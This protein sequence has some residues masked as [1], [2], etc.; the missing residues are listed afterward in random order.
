MIQII[1]CTLYGGQKMLINDF[2]AFNKLA[3]FSGR[4]A[5]VDSPERCLAGLK[6]FESY[7]Y[8]DYDYKFNSWG[9]RGPEYDQY[10]GK[11]VNIC[12]GDSYTTNLGGP[13]EHSWPSILQE[14]Y[15]IPC[16]NLGL[17]GAGNDAIRLIYERA[18]K[19]FDVKKTFIQYSLIHRRLENGVLMHKHAYMYTNIHP[20][21]TKD[22]IIHFQQNFVKGAYYNFLPPWF[23][24]DDEL[25]FINSIPGFAGFCV[26]RWHYWTKD[27]PRILCE[28]N[29]YN[30]LKGPDWPSFEDFLEGAEPH[31][32]MFEE[33]YKVRTRKY[34][35]R[36]GLHFSLEGNQLLAEN[37]YNQ[38]K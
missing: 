4:Y 14:K 1:E 34:R 13:L 19:I 38:T 25:E 31:P 22:N 32:D 11:P 27:D 20:F 2:E 28:E 15:D 29:A 16:V 8:Q 33:Q 12:L 26:D 24:Q 10:I 18:C 5:S 23:Y 3:N 30:E 6:W 9:F 7:P 36:D 17:N 35:G 37:L 21:E